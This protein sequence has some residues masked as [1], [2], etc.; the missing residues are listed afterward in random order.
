MGYLVVFMRSQDKVRCA[1]T[2]I[3]SLVFLSFAIILKFNSDSKSTE[4][5]SN[6]KKTDNTYYMDSKKTSRLSN[7]LSS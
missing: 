1:V 5:T 7:T 3:I 2:I 4:N 6:D